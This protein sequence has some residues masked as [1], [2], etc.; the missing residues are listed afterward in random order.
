MSRDRIVSVRLTDA[1]H[2]ELTKLG[3]PSDVVR[4]ALKVLAAVMRTPMTVKTVPLDTRGAPTRMTWSDGTVG[5][6]WPEVKTRVS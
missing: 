1:E 3:K 4:R 5:P 6:N 2:S